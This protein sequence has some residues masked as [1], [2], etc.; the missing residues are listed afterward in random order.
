MKFDNAKEYCDM[1]MLREALSGIKNTTLH[2]RLSCLLLKESV[3]SKYEIKKYIDFYNK[4][5]ANNFIFRQLMDYDKSAKN[6]EK[7]D[8]CNANKVDLND[9]WSE[10]DHDIEFI[11]YLNLL[12]YYYYV[13]L[14]KYHDLMIA[15]ESANLNQQYAEKSRNADVIYE[16]AFHNNGNLCGSWIDTEDVL[17]IYDSNEYK[18]KWRNLKCSKI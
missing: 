12:G 4:L 8:Y 15:S 2:H 6:T 5:G 10:F 7:M 16:M 1:G 9:I 11:P 3:N 17:D 18:Y 13:E 14:Y